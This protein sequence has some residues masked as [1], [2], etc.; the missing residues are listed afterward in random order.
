VFATFYDAYTAAQSSITETGIP[1]TI[2]IDDSIDD[3]MIQLL[4]TSG[5]GGTASITTVSGG[6]MTITGMSSMIAPLVGQTLVVYAAA[7]SGN[8]GTFPIV[9]VLSPSS[10]IVANAS[11]VAD[12]A[13]NG[14]IGWYTQGVA[15]ASVTAFDGT[16]ATITGLSGIVSGDV[17]KVITFT[18][19]SNGGNNGTFVI[20]NYIS[21]TSVQVTNVNAVT[22]DEAN[23]TICWT[24]GFDY[25]LSQIT[26][27]GSTP[28]EEFSTYI[29]IYDGNTWNEGFLHITGGLVALT[30]FSNQLFLGTPS[31]L[32]PMMTIDE[33]SV[34]AVDYNGGIFDVSLYAPFVYLTIGSGG[35]AGSDS[36][37]TT[38][39]I[40]CGSNAGTGGDIYILTTQYN[41]FDD[42]F[43]A[44]TPSS[45]G[46][47]FQFYMQGP[48]YGDL[49][50]PFPFLPYYSG[51]INVYWQGSSASALTP[52]S[53]SGSFPQPSNAGTASGTF[54]VQY[55]SN[56]VTASVA[57]TSWSGNN[58]NLI[59]ASQP[60]VVYK[61]SEVGGNT[62][63]L[64]ENYTGV[65]P[66]V[67]VDVTTG[68]AEVTLTS[69]STSEF[70]VGQQVT[71]SGG[72]PTVSGNYTISSLVDG[73]HL[74]LTAT[75]TGPSSTGATMAGLNVITTAL[76]E[77]GFYPGNVQ[78]GM[79]YYDES[80]TQ[81]YWWNGSAWVPATLAVVQGSG[82]T[83]VGQTLVAT[84]EGTASWQNP[85]LNVVH[86]YVSSTQSTNLSAGDHVK[87]NSSYFSVGSDIALDSSSSYTTTLGA[88][89]IGRITLAANH[90]YKLTFSPNEGVGQGAI[91][92]EWRDANNG[93][94]I[95]VG[96]RLDDGQQGSPPTAGDHATG[97]PCV[98]YYQ[99]SGSPGLVEVVITYNGGFTALGEMAAAP[100]YPWFSIEEIA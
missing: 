54:T 88:P 37:A 20:T 30:E 64:N 38:A 31:Q 86:G 1:S 9:E 65:P 48:Y 72:S 14:E 5:E 52:F 7:S 90:T 23:G 32:P 99:T 4:P 58:V 70:T 15:S 19:V 16:L 28:T 35:Y 80:S 100:M 53:G 67:T 27:T 45:F 21:A 95:G 24:L 49:S 43:V 66:S 85:I 61:V 73:T 74:I 50:N 22:P 84:G 33:N 3:C 96:T 78:E 83:A 97:A 93:S 12:D 40:N 77:S 17:G 56:I 87:F 60:G 42:S 51:G 76:Y 69:G 34:M 62:V 68:N 11:A 2:V 8:N 63:Y 75:F 39:F 91:Y 94:S 6:N 81:P 79:M 55:N 26:L 82:P 92:F 36:S 29:G 25:N 13:N 47:S 71:F 57:Q 98:G 41:F 18:N 59:F 10:V 46:T 89:S 44:G